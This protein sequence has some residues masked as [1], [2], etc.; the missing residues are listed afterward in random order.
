[1][2]IVALAKEV[3]GKALVKISGHAYGFARLHMELIRYIGSKSNL[4]TT[5]FLIFRNGASLIISIY[6]GS[7]ATRL[8]NFDHDDDMASSTAGMMKVILNQISK[9]NGN[10]I[11]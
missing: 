1:L 4:S 9:V 7:V 8:T 5:L 6:P 2:Q 10:F 11:K 3:A